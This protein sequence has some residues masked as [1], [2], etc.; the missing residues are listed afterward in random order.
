MS[1]PMNLIDYWN[2]LDNQARSAYAAR[3]GTS[4]LNIS[5][6]YIPRARKIPRQH[7]LALMAEASEGRVSMEEVVRHF[8][9]QV[10]NRASNQQEAANG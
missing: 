10:N 8:Y 7:R 1:S 4:V 2:S 3:V 9:P 6:H 5:C